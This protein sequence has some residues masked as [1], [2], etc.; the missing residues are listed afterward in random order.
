MKA[1]IQ[2][3]I[4][5]TLKTSEGRYSRMSIIIASAWG[6]AYSMAIADFFIEG[7]RL[8][9]WMTLVGTAVGT[10]WVDKKSESIIPKENNQQNGV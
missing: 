9:V 1:I 6:L 5:H 3:V 7:F 8:D 2:Q 4:D 10:K